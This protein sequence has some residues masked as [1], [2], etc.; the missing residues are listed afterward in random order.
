MRLVIW[1]VVLGLLELAEAVVYRL[2]HFTLHVHQV[3]A[4]WRR[5]ADLRCYLAETEIDLAA[6]RRAQQRGGR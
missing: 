1:W 4:A 5:E 6:Q 2:R 3:V